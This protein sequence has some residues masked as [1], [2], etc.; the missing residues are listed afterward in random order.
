M[1]AIDIDKQTTIV[2]PMSRTLGFTNMYTD[3]KAA[4]QNFLEE[5]LSKLEGRVAG[6]LARFKKA[7]EPGNPRSPLHE[8]S[9]TR[10]DVSSLSRNTGTPPFAEGSSVLWTSTVPMTRK[11]SKCTC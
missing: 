2:M 3:Y 6:V 1:N 9:G 8:Q 7:N 5:E 11:S 10:F 4:K